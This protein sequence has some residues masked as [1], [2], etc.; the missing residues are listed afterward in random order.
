M[1]EIAEILA[2]HDNATMKRVF[3]VFVSVLS[4]STPARVCDGDPVQ[5]LSCCAPTPEVVRQI[6]ERL[7]VE[8]VPA[9]PKDEKRAVVHCLIHALT[10]HILER[11]YACLGTSAIWWM[12]FRVRQILSLEDVAVPAAVL[13]QLSGE[14]DGQLYPAILAIEAVDQHRRRAETAIHFL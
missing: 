10:K 4:S 3:E 6:Y 13:S 9:M 12:A 8:C 11:R 7:E 5:R 2:P 1:L 14:S